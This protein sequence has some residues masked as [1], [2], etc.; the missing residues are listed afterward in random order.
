M[1]AIDACIEEDLYIIVATVVWKE[2]AKSEEFR[3]FVKFLND[4]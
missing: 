2:R 1:R 3:N 4:K